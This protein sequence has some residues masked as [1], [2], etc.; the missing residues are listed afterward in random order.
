MAVGLR[1]GGP[2]PRGLRAFEQVTEAVSKQ[3]GRPVSGTKNCPDSSRRYK[4]NP[5]KL[6]RF[7]SSLGRRVDPLDP[8]DLIFINDFRLV[9]LI[10]VDARVHLDNAVTLPLDARRILFAQWL[11]S[12]GEISTGFNGAPSWPRL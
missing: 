11:E 6:S 3:L 7:L 12:L 8:E 5:V 1:E 4:R 10:Y 9:P 2:R